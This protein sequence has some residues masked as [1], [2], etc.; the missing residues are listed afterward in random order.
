MRGCKYF[1]AVML[2]M[3]ASLFTSGNLIAGS[4]QYFENLGD[5]ENCVGDL[6]D[7]V[8]TGCASWT[9]QVSLYV[10]ANNYASVNHLESGGFNSLSVFT[11]GGTDN[12]VSYDFGLALGARIPFGC[13]CKAFRV[14]VEGAFRG[15][16][17]L[18][19]DSLQSE[20]PMQMYQVDYEDRW[21]VMTNF[22]LDFPLKN[23][24]TFYI[25]GGIGAN[26]GRVSVNDTIVSGSTRYDNF[27]WQIGG[28]VTWEHSERWTVDVGYRYMDYGATTVN[29]NANFNPFPAAGN[30]IADLTS[31]QLMVGFRFN[32]LGNLIGRR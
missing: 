1:V 10:S 31:H 17:G 28:G 21:S 13:K 20:G 30:Y 5:F 22:W 32:S 19:T 7:C 9:D 4:A 23:S 6:E 24:K 16:G 25:G 3:S 2:A 12:N 29:L 18:E 27:A 11:N 14:E 8:S 15:L 26:G